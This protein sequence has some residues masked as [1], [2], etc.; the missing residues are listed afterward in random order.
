MVFFPRAASSIY[1]E[2]KGESTSPTHAPLSQELNSPEKRA[3]RY[4]APPLWLQ[5]YCWRPKQCQA[6]LKEEKYEEE[7]LA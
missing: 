7:Y 4:K 1:M 3:K 6:S 2:H 5:W